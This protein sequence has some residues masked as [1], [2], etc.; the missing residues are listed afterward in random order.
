MTRAAERHKPH[1]AAPPLVNVKSVSQSKHRPGPP[2]VPAVRSEPQRG[3][4]QSYRSPLAASSWQRRSTS[5]TGGKSV[6]SRM[7]RETAAS[8]ALVA[9]HSPSRVVGSLPCSA[10][11][12]HRTGLAD[13][14][15]I[16]ARQVVA[17]KAPC[18]DSGHRLRYLERRTLR[19]ALIEH[20]DVV[21]GEP[22]LEHVHDRDERPLAEAAARPVQRL[23]QRLRYV[24]HLSTPTSQK[25]SPRNMSI[26]PLHPS[27][28][29][30]T[31]GTLRR[32]W[33]WHLRRSAARDTRR[34]AL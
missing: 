16:G 30:I 14:S 28:G 13:G 6:S 3:Q 22:L 4:L 34:R 29:N 19:P 31:A 17:S 18:R 9:H 2:M 5:A 8:A 27:R 33:R 11:C 32:S 25:Q 24:T 7:R 21:G 12:H 26:T 10:C 23:Q 1:T 15:L 20:D